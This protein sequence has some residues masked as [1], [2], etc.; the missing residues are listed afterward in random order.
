M[1]SS[2]VCKYVYFY[3]RK[4]LIYFVIP[5]TEGAATN[6]TPAP[7]PTQTTPVTTFSFMYFQRSSK[8]DFTYTCLLTCVYL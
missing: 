5:A 7:T 6:I 2:T 8:T 3:L 1:C 4:N